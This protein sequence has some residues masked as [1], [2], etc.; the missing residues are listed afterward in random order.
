VD[1]SL[2]L[3]TRGNRTAPPRQQT[4]RAAL[5]WSYGLLSGRERVLFQRLAVFVW[6]HPLNCLT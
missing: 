6:M 3:L 2:Q 5:D 4:M 1:D